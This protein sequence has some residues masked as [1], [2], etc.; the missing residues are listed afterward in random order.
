MTA[1][2]AAALEPRI[3]RPQLAQ[4]LQHRLLALFRRAGEI[5]LSPSAHVLAEDGIQQRI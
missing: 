4:E 5:N 2:G 3:I 1:Q